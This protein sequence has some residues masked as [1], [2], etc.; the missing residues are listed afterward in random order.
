METSE[1]E[2]IKTTIENTARYIRDNRSQTEMYPVVGVKNMV[3][4]S[5]GL[6]I[7]LEGST[8]DPEF[9]VVVRNELV[10]QDCQR[11]NM[12]D[13]YQ[14]DKVA[15]DLQKDLLDEKKL[16]GIR[17]CLITSEIEEEQ[18]KLG[19]KARERGY[20]PMFWDWCHDVFRFREGCY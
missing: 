17:I 20:F 9:W 7:W 6:M 15:V 2:S 19:R 12:N 1:I 13:D 16:G 4:Q 14:M 11:G 5:D 3:V 10:K 18:W 8:L